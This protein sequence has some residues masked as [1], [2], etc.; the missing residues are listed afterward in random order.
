MS[1]PLSRVYLWLLAVAGCLALSLLACAKPPDMPIDL[2]DMLPPQMTPEGNGCDVICPLPP[3]PEPQAGCGQL[4]E[5]LHPH[6]P[7]PPQQVWQPKEEGM[8]VVPAGMGMSPP[9]KSLLL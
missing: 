1:K 2:Q 9:H 5:V 3:M 4:P 6:F 8:V 7:P